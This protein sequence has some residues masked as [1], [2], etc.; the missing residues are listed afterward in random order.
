MMQ[1]RT[2]Q[3]S[4][5]RAALAVLSAGCLITACNNPEDALVKAEREYSFVSDNGGDNFE[6]CAAARK[7]RQAALEAENANQYKY[8]T[9]L[10][11][12]NCGSAELLGR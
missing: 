8:W 6:L 4:K 10:A 5:T 1:G 12:V 2:G 11:N 9:P 7:A 3:V